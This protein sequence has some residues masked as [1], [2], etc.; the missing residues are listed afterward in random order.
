MH[1]NIVPKDKD[2]GL[3]KKKPEEN[4]ANVN[5]DGQAIENVKSYIYLGS[6]F[7]WVNE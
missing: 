6:E 2:H 7:T 5:I 1:I 4:D 3:W